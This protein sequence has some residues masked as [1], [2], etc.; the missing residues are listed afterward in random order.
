MARAAKPETEFDL[1]EPAPE[2]PA[3]DVALP[4][5]LLG[6][7]HIDAEL[8]RGGMAVV[9]RGHDPK[10]HRSFAIKRALH[11]SDTRAGRELCA[12]FEREFQLLAQL[13]H[14][15]VI[16]VYDYGVQ[17]GRPYYTME[18]LDGG[19]LRELSPLPWRRVCALIYDVASSL[20]LLHSRRFVHRDISPRNVRC[21][22]S[23]F[24]KLIDFG[25]AVPM[26]V[27]QHIV[28]T[29]AFVAP[30]ALGRSALDARSDLFALGATCYY[31]L[32]GQLPFEAHHLSELNEAWTSTPYRPS[33][34]VDDVPT[35]LDELVMSL[36][37]LEPTQRP[38]SAFE[39]MQRLA[40]IAELPHDESQD[41]SKAYLCA[42]ITVGREREL[43]ALRH[44]VLAAVPS[45]GSSPR[46]F[47]VMLTASAGAGRTHML[48]AAA[49]MGKTLGASVLRA[50]AES[51]GRRLALA[52]ALLTQ[53]G[54]RAPQSTLAAAQAESAS[55]LLSTPDG[56]MGEALVPAALDPSADLAQVRDATARLL[57]RVGRATPLLIIVDDVDALDEISLALVTELVQG[58][59]EPYVSLLMACDERAAREREPLRVLAQ[60]SQTL[61]LPALD[62]AATLQLL[63]SI[64]GD[65]PNVAFVSDEIYQRA[66]GNPGATLWSAQWLI[67]RAA[68][69]YA[70]GA[71]TLPAQLSEADLP[72]SHEQAVLEHFATLSPLARELAECQALAV[73]NVFSHEQYAMLA[74]DQPSANVERALIELVSARV[75]HS[76][77]GLHS[78]TQREYARL[79]LA[80]DKPSERVRQHTALARMF[81][82]SK[83]PLVYAVPHLLASGQEQAA[84]DRLLAHFGED[85]KLSGDLAADYQLPLRP[86]ALAKIYR[87]CLACAQG[88]AMPLRTLSELRR[89]VVLVSVIETDASYWAAGPAWRAQLERESGWTRYQE[90]DASLPDLDR[91]GRAYAETQAVFTAA[92]AEHRAYPPDEAI[93]LLVHYVVISIAIA[94]RSL[95]APLARS[96]PCLLEPFAPLS[97][98]LSA[99]WQNAL[100][101]C[102]YQDLNY[103]SARARW[104]KVY[105]S[106]GDMTGADLRYVAGIRNAI[107]C[108]VATMDL[109]IGRADVERWLTTLDHDPMQRVHAMYLRKLAALQR[110]D[111][112]A[113]DRFRKDAELLALNDRTQQMFTTLLMT[114]LLTHNLAGD[115]SGLK[116]VAQRIEE[117]AERYAKWRSIARVAEAT[118]QL[119]CGN[120]A[121]ARQL[122]ED[123]FCECEPRQCE[124]GGVLLAFCPAAA[125]YVEVLDALGERELAL[126]WGQQALSQ[127]QTRHVDV[128]SWDLEHTVALVEAQ[129][130]DTVEA[131]RQRLAR[132]LQVQ[133]EAGA[134]GLRLGLTYEA[135][136][137]VAIH[138]RDAAGAREYARL[139]ALEYRH[140]LG[141]LLSTRYERLRVEGQRAGIDLPS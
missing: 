98:V 70:A 41:V 59:D 37:S 42:P 91:L 1:G 136:A 126:R 33:Q 122:L 44:N 77:G 30:E 93:R 92:E 24:A 18:L 48:D 65:V 86:Q 110:G 123:C 54:E 131:A 34:L 140:G 105:E 12:L 9:Y 4:A 138:T 31:A 100:A 17:D 60:Y 66:Q 2:A 20:A 57:W 108:G 132:L 46:R 67:D 75:I 55:V 16:E 121:E 3:N 68:I 129:R 97:P 6:R 13:T 38:R 116:H 130:P 7:Y 47:V 134:T 109:T 88:R 56:S 15:R 94:L 23:G 69:R 49:L 27:A 39:V 81:I 5:E 53:L 133:R 43:S 76:Q 45:D 96:L 14:P 82:E 64:F 40:A 71:W 117:T 78:L 8:G 120:L 89:H 113:A 26:G 19:D 137:R 11:S 52:N 114:E 83:A 84:V 85:D 141:S 80:Q 111:A 32:T 29:P 25:A 119:R 102:E 58:N 74:G 87:D 101:T 50:G 106:L 90:L 124:D 103:L 21:T 35:A 128:M 72:L 36:L 112:E 139:T 61:A 125:A 104:L 10:S 118:F 115:L 135:C 99:I 62:S 127:L 51:S 28:G 79:L 73:H 95:N 63:T 107:A 22:R